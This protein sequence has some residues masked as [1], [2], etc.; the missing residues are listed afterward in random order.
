MPPARKSQLPAAAV[1][2]VVG[3]LLGLSRV[4]GYPLVRVGTRLWACD[5]YLRVAGVFPGLP[6]YQAA[7]GPVDPV[8]TR[9]SR[10]PA[11]QVFESRTSCLTLGSVEIPS[12]SA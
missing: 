12:V 1:D 3:F 10:V 8:P 7:R 4:P 5:A 11:V 2:R 9:E 6:D